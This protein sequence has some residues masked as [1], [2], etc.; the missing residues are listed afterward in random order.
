MENEFK[1]LIGRAFEEIARQAVPEIMF[2]I[3]IMV[4]PIVVASAV[5]LAFEGVTGPVEPIPFVLALIA[6]AITAW[7][8]TGWAIWV[9]DRKN[10]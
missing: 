4:P 8:S 9:E 1:G 5:M 7:F 10:S 3:R 2:I 6:C